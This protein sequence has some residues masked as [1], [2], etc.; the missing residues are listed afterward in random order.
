MVIFYLSVPQSNLRRLLEIFR[1][2]C[3]QRARN[4]LTEAAKWNHNGSIMDGECCAHYF[5]TEEYS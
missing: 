1:F 5:D 3:M 2:S 4:T